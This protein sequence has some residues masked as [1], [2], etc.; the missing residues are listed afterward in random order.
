ME[1]RGCQMLG[2]RRTHR[3]KSVPE[4]AGL[5]L[6]STPKASDKTRS[7][8]GEVKPVI[9]DTDTMDAG[10]LIKP[11]CPQYSPSAVEG[12]RGRP[13]Q[14]L[15]LAYIR[16]LDS[17]GTSLVRQPLVEGLTRHGS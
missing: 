13:G 5:E 17:Q 2:T 11:L 10:V 3:C 1:T 16:S 9:K 12:L 6:N 14:T 4:Q 15:G 7:S 8:H